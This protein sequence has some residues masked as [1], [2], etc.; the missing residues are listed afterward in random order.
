MACLAPSLDAPKKSE[1]LVDFRRV[2][3]YNRYIKKEIIMTNEQRFA[4]EVT[5]KLN[6]KLGTFMVDVMQKSTREEREAAFQKWA[7]KNPQAFEF[8]RRP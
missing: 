8:K 3:R 2:C 5:R 7:Q 4:K 6:A 1:N